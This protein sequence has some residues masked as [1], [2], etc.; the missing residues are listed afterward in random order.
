ME[1]A[2]LLCLRFDDP[3]RAIIRRAALAVVRSA[4]ERLGEPVQEVAVEAGIPVLTA[5]SVKTGLDIDWDDPNARN[6]A[7]G[8]LLKQVQALGSFLQSELS[9][10]FSKAPLKEHWDLVQKLI[11]QDPDPDPDP[12]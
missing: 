3:R 5:T 7:L 6:V 12:A 4:A 11:E 8:S 1:V 2:W 9:T 10:E